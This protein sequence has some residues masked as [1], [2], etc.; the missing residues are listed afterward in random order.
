MGNRMTGFVLLSGCDHPQYQLWSREALRGLSETRADGLSMGRGSPCPGQEDRGILSGS[1]WPP[2]QALRVGLAPIQHLG[3]DVFAPC[4]LGQH[5]HGIPLFI[6]PRSCSGRNTLPKQS[7]GTSQ[8]LRE[9]KAAATQGSCDV[10]SD[11][12]ALSHSPFRKLRTD[13]GLLAHHTSLCLTPR[14]H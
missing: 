5:S 1:L 9:L 4:G 3:L 14:K 11:L 6:Y 7:F 8:M 2:F 10:E 13:P 12:V